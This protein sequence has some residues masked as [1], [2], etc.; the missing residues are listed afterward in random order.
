MVP[1]IK[2]IPSIYS[3]TTYLGKNGVVIEEIKNKMM[4]TIGIDT[5]K[6]VVVPLVA[7]GLFVDSFDFKKI[8]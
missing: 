4:L 2:L 1:E 8:S 3:I 7:H 6:N 5:K